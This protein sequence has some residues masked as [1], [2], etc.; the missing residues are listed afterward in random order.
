MECQESLQFHDPYF[1]RLQMGFVYRIIALSVDCNNPVERD[2]RS[3]IQL[4]K[5]IFS[6]ATSVANDINCL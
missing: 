3:W 1:E 4:K 2:P 6:S 5:F